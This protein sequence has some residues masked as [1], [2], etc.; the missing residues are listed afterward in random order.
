[1]AVQNNVINFVTQASLGGINAMNKALQSQL[2]T[3]RA[4]GQTK[5]PGWSQGAGGQM[6][7]PAGQFASKA[8]YQ[9]AVAAAGA[10]AKQINQQM[11]Q[12]SA[13]AGQ[14]LAQNF[15]RGANQGAQA[16]IASLGRVAN[17]MVSGLG[18]AASV[19]GG[20]IR[21]GLGGAFTA[22]SGTVK[23]LTSAVGGLSRSLANI[24]TSAGLLATIFGAKAIQSASQVQ[25]ALAKV[26]TIARTTPDVLDEIGDGLTRMSAT[27]SK[28]FAD[29]STGFYDL[30]SAGLGMKDG[31]VQVADGMTLMK[32]AT[33]LAVGGIGSVDQSVDLLTS[34]LNAFRL[35][36]SESTH[37]VDVF[38]KAVELGKVTTGEISEVIST[39]SPL[40][41]SMGLS[42]EEV[43]AALAVMTQQGFTAGES[44]TAM[45][46]ALVGV[47]RNSK[48]L[49]RAQ[50]GLAADLAAAGV[51][52]IQELVAVKGLQPAMALLAKESERTGVPLIKM[53]G[54]IEGVQYVLGTTGK[55]AGAFALAMEAMSNS[56]GSAAEQAA[57]RLASFSEQMKI[58]QNAVFELGAE[59]GESL[60][61][62]MTQLIGGVSGAVRGITDFVR[63]NKGF[64]DVAAPILGVVSALLALQASASL[65]TG[66]AAR[67]GGQL[68]ALSL[69]FAGIARAIFAVAFPLAIAVGAF[70][71]FQKAVTENLAGFGQ[72]GKALFAAEE[73]IDKFIDVIKAGVDAIGAIFNALVTGS[74]ASHAIDKFVDSFGS[75][76]S[77][78]VDDIKKAI[79]VVMG[80]LAKLLPKIVN[81]AVDTARSLAPVVAGIA[82]ALWNWVQ[83]VAAVVLAGL[84]SLVGQIGAFIGREAPNVANALRTLLLGAMQWIGRDILPKIG[85]ALSGILDGIVN[86]LRSDN[87]VQMI[88]RGVGQLAGAFI[89]GLIIIFASVTEWIAGNADQIV[90]AF[91]EFGKQVIAGF[92]QG[93]R[94]VSPVLADIAQVVVAVV[95][96]A[97][98]AWKVV[99]LAIGVALGLWNLAR[100]IQLIL[101][102]AAALVSGGIPAMIAFGVATTGATA[103]TVALAIAIGVVLAPLALLAIA[104]AAVGVAAYNADQEAKKQS[105]NLAAS[106]PSVDAAAERIRK[107]GGATSSL[108]SSLDRTT[109]ALVRARNA[110]RDLTDEQLRAQRLWANTKVWIANEEAAK[111][112]R[113]TV[114][115]AFQDSYRAA[116]LFHRH[117]EEAA[118]QMA[119]GMS[120]VGEAAKKA[121]EEV[122]G[123]GT[124]A[125]EAALAAGTAFAAAVEKVSSYETR[126]P[127]VVDILIDSIRKSKPKFR[128]AA[129]EGLQEYVTAWGTEAAEQMPS[130]GEQTILGLIEFMNEAAESED[131][132]TRSLAAGISIRM[133]EALAKGGETNI[134]PVIGDLMATINAEFAKGT[135]AAID[136]ATDWMSG[137]AEGFERT[138]IPRARPTRR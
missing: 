106:G 23:T 38:A 121:A 82:Q 75:F 15:A 111:R 90:A 57:L 120:G 47:Q 9:Q 63:A 125:L 30:L 69:G 72:F 86:F 24:A 44:M 137:I 84:G 33:D 131:S 80:E 16:A 21:M 66:V 67:F 37:V 77:L 64:F 43:G 26:N 124:A 107:Y 91:V 34:V 31:V 136:R 4:I 135:P 71:A 79:P 13:Q 36:L 49:Q 61:P 14:A 53:L 81:W 5:P 35:D 7:N 25:D 95:V 93:M 101:Q 6:R 55:Q 8:Q 110:Q 32:D 114:P 70:L 10:A 112:L 1:M 12:A 96:P 41:S 132:A 117:L 102:T 52:T 116:A 133:A 59:I 85:P 128:A 18:A 89:G 40:A 73:R 20:A 105:D 115:L 88:S 126:G 134:L 22:V 76:A 127:K 56:S 19:A 60:L 104:F 2:S 65:M 108:G 123:F 28:S 27:S 39:V 68:G 113:E 119:A 62:P 42:I 51:A 78:L 99:T 83:E 109:P 122:K 17:A 98:I 45:R 29:L 50:K 87:S 11:A 100:T 94:D 138:R 130:L 74:D 48:F 118:P 92:F 97:F 129:V 58:L 46:S 103:A 54:R 3:L